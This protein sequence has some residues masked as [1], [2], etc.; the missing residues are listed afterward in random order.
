MRVELERENIKGIGVVTGY[1][2]WYPGFNGSLEDP[3]E[4]SEILEIDLTDENGEEV[5]AETIFENEDLLKNLEDKVFGVLDKKELEKATN[6]FENTHDYTHLV[7][8]N[9]KWLTSYLALSEERTNHKVL[10]EEV[11][12]VIEQLNRAFDEERTDLS[13]IEVQE[14]FEWI[15]K[16]IWK[17]W[18]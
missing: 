14:A 3:P 7:S 17:L 13:M 4:D 5:D 2:E 8:A 18:C 15:G 11:R 12:E 10:H 9:I 6:P 16:N 1:I